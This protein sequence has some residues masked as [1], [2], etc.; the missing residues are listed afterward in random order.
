MKKKKKKK[1]KGYWGF[2]A[3]ALIFTLLSFGLGGYL[4]GS[5]FEF[6]RIVKGSAADGLLQDVPAGSALSINA[7]DHDP[8]ADTAE[9]K[10][11]GLNKNMGNRDLLKQET[12][13]QTDHGNVIPDDPGIYAKE[14]SGA[15]EEAVPVTRESINEEKKTDENEKANEIAGNK[16][17][18]ENNT[19]GSGYYINIIENTSDETEYV[20]NNMENHIDGPG[21]DLNKTDKNADETEYESNEAENKTDETGYNRSD[22]DEDE[23]VSY[24]LLKH[25]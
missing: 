13:Y 8:A 14:G 10:I 9:I 16:D 24:I 17:E 12:D 22:Y 21:Y 1:V 18:I 11:S 3:A 4:T 7:A 20:L 15:G 2:G 6:R 19:D 5:Y 23:D 25:R